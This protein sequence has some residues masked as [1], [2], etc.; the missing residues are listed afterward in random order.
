MG[1]L[2]IG[3]R[4]LDEIRARIG[5]Q[6]LLKLSEMV[7]WVVNENVVHAVAGERFASL[8]VR[9]RADLVD[10]FDKLDFLAKPSEKP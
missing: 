6:E 9:G 2:K 4:A 10:A 7:R 5:R 8:R 1:V 3:A